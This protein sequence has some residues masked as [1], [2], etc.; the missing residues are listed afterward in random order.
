MLD[1]YN[2]YIGRLQSVLVPE[3]ASEIERLALS[4]KDAWETKNKFSFVETVEV[5]EMQFISQMILIT[6]SIKKWNG[7]SCG[8]F[9]CERCRHYLPCQ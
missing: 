6:V 5:P 8:S 9:T 7:T 2:A 1:H 3:R 4:L